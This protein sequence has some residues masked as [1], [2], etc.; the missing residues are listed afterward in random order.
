M[1]KSFMGKVAVVTD[2]AHGI[3]KAIAEAFSA[4]GVTVHMVTK[5]LL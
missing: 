1:T 4:E 2:E 5:H 3:G